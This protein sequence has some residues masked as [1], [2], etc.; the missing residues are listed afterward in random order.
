M[1]NVMQQNGAR[2]ADNDW[3]LLLDAAYFKIPNKTDVPAIAAA[4]KKYFTCAEQRKAGLEGIWIQFYFDSRKRFSLRCYPIEQ[5]VSP[6]FR[7]GCIWRFYH[8]D[9]DTALH[10]PEFFQ[11]NGCPLQWEVKRNRN[12]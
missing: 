6:S 10:M 4:M 1:D 7:C 11:Y 2:V 9:T 5:F 8:R 3:S 12:S